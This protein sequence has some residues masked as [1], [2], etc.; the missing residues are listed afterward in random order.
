MLREVRCDG[1]IVW[2]WVYEYD[3]DEA[4]VVCEMVSD[5]VRRFSL[6]FK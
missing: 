5:E 3:D 2:N 6:P 4:S 1:L